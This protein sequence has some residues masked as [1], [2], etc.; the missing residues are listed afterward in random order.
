M[1]EKLN[2]LKQMLFEIYDLNGMIA[3][4]DWDQ[5]TNMP[6][7]GAEDRGHHLETLSRIIHYKSTSEELERLLEALLPDAARMDSAADDAC[8][9]RKAQRTLEKEKKVPVQWVTEFA[10]LTTMAQ[11]AWEKAKDQSSYGVFKP[12]LKRVIEM[13]REYS[14]FF[15]P[16]AHIYDPQ[17]DDFEEGLK[18][19]EIVAIFDVLRPRQVELL[20]QIA[21][22]PQIDDRFLHLE[23]DPQGQWDFGVEVLGQMGFDWTRGRQ[24]KSAHPFTTTIGMDDVRITTRVISDYLPSSLFSSIHEMGH[25]LY[26]QGFARSLSR[27]LLASGTSMAV[28]ESQSRLWEN[29]V[30]RSLPFWKY[31]YP[32]LQSRF[33]A[34]LG[35]V[36][37]ATFYR[38]IN[39][40]TPSLIRTESDEATY[41][42]HIMLRL[43]M[44]I[45]MLDGSVSVDDLPEAW[46]QRMQS[47][48]GLT[49]PDDTQGVLQDIHWSFGGIGYFPTYALGNVIS[50][51]WWEKIGMDLP[52]LESQMQKGQFGDLLDWL[53]QNIHRHGA[54][55]EPQVLVEKVTGSKIIPQPYL[56]YLEN[57]YKALYGI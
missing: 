7:G 12:H 11:S 25:A 48:I 57:K 55:F 36:D 3:L 43:E 46:N 47:Y 29:L 31:F 15:M 21:G 53:R 42:L 37:L 33:A 14:S 45:A 4:A 24:D 1:Q 10:R 20:R 16:Y 54:K 39:R 44:E 28:H 56:N 19:A 13:R 50:A 23:Y 49:P 51:Q 9:I 18:T 52:D 17:I 6:E 38:G 41:N 30:G 34:Q 35:N 22:R 2:Q 5:K 27:T 8:L 40:V 32:R 26:E